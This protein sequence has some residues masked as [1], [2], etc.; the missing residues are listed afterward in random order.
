MRNAPAGRHTK[1]ALIACRLA[2]ATLTA[3][4]AFLLY[5]APVL[6]DAQQAKIHRIGYI[7]AVIPLSEL[8]GAEPQSPAIRA[9]VRGL[10]DLGYVHGRN[11]IL[12]MRTLE[13]HYERIE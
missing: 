5:W 4:V 1:A 12:D 11:L 3:A 2:K 6:A 7:A 8:T 10:R 13:G 9:F